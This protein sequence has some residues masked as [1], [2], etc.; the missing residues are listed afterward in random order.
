MTRGSTTGDFAL[1]TSSTRKAFGEGG[2]SQ[3]D[4]FFLSTITSRRE[5]ALEAL[6]RPA[7][8]CTKES[9]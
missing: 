4:L 9:E 6:L 1:G 2:A 5:A 7:D 8:A 3:T